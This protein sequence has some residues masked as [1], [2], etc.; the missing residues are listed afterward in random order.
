MNSL[1]RELTSLELKKLNSNKGLFALMSKEPLSV[2]RALR[3]VDYE[4]K[5][6]RLQTEFIRMQKWIIQNKKRLIVIFEGR[7]AAIIELMNCQLVCLKQ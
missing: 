2:E 6:K 1:N 5:L 7:D 4:R 3:Y